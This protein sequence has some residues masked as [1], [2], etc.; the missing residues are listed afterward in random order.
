[1]IATTTTTADNMAHKLTRSIMLLRTTLEHDDKVVL[2]IGN[3]GPCFFVSSCVA[4][5]PSFPSQL[6]G[7]NITRY[8]R[9]FQEEDQ[10]SLKAIEE[11]GNPPL[12]YAILRRYRDRYLF[13]TACLGLEPWI[14]GNLYGRAKA[15][16]SSWM[17]VI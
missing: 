6:A 13:T 7:W 15:N 1:M 14:S 11:G 10:E 3:P 5:L 12:T 2:E 17:M 16:N 8:F 4:L 9:A